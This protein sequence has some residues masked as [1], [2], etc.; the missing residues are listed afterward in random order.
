[1]QSLGEAGYDQRVATN[2]A[3]ALSVTTAFVQDVVADCNP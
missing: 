1:M 2:A 3:A